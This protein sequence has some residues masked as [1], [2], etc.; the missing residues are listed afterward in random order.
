[1]S[2]GKYMSMS[3]AATPH[4]DQH[5]SVANYEAMSVANYEATTQWMRM[6]VGGETRQKSAKLWAE[7]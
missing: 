1:M 2:V 3:R 4:Q 6:K 7:C 5:M